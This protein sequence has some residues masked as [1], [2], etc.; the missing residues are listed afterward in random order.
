MTKTWK[1]VSAGDIIIVHKNHYIPADLLFLSAENEEGICYIETMQL[2]GET[3]LKIKK[4]LDETKDMR[5]AT[6]GQFAGTVHCEPPNSRL[7]QFTG[8]LDLEPP[9]VLSTS[10]VPLTPAAILLRGCSLRNTNRVFGLVIYA[11]VCVTELGALRCSIA[12]STGVALQSE[13]QQGAVEES[14]CQLLAESE[15]KGAA[16]LKVCQAAAWHGA[17]ACNRSHQLSSLLL[18]LC[19][20]LS[21]LSPPRRAGHDT[22]IFMNA[23][24]PPSK[25]SSIE[26]SVDYI[27]F[28]MF[29]LLFSMC[30]TGC[31]YFAWWTS[32]YMPLHWY[33][34]PDQVED[35]VEYNSSRPAIVGV[36]NFITSFILYGEGAGLV[37]GCEEEE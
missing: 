7:Y 5:E 15:R 4:A 23:T 32:T 27:I 11:G 6:I 9:L 14:L 10:K 30:I 26:R 35:A 21:H 33:L 31:I 1:D 2:D 13:V 36:T 22:K 8:N 25:R 24:Q 37:F 34:G 3:N 16:A 12:L 19:V 28:F 20:A 29:A 17:C 18:C